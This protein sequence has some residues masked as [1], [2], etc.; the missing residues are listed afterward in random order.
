MTAVEKAEVVTNCDHLRQLKF[1]PVLPHAFTEHGAI[2]AANVLNS[3]RAIETSVLVVRAFVRLRQMALTHAD[4]ARRLDGLESKYDAN[5]K[6]V[7]DV[8]RRLMQPTP[9]PSRPR[10]GFRAADGSTGES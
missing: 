3:D 9:A 1:S 7:F 6:V 2:M 5:F 4:L 8:I 10:I